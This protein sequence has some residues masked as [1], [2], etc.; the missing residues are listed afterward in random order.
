MP[1]STHAAPSASGSIVGSSEVLHQSRTT[2]AAPTSQSLSTPASY[3]NL[4]LPST[5]GEM[6]FPTP[7][8]TQA[9]PTEPQLSQ[10]G[11]STIR[12][13]APIRIGL[14]RLDASSRLPTP[15]LTQA[16]AG[17]PLDPTLFGAEDASVDLLPDPPAMPGVG[18][19]GGEAS[20]QFNLSFGDM[21]PPPELPPAP[22]PSTSNLYGEGC[23]R[24][25]CRSV[26]GCTESSSISTRSGNRGETEEQ[27]KGKSKFI[28]ML[29]SIC[30]IS[31]Q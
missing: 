30:K 13:S 2:F 28:S 14:T 22:S 7:P 27:E 18:N 9:F 24:A 11:P 21:P 5:S 12:I 31:V 16:L 20:G 3:P 29:S 19:V 25:R 26:L 23:R 4:H 10:P 6:S 1:S 15:P 8:A 17:F